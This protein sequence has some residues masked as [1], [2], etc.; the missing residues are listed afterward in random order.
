MDAQR[1]SHPSYSRRDVTGG[2][3]QAFWPPN[4][5][6]IEDPVTLVA[7]VHD[8]VVPLIFGPLSISWSQGSGGHNF[9]SRDISR[10]NPVVL[11]ANQA[12]DPISLIG[13]EPLIDPVF[14]LC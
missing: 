9:K 10:W 14:W 13:A 1:C 11:P 6:C 4:G 3:A 7:G 12:T 8:R 5:S 2:S